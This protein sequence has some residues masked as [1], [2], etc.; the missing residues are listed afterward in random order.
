MIL[1][2]FT[3]VLASPLW[4][5][6]NNRNDCGNNSLS[7]NWTADL[8]AERPIFNDEDGEF[9]TLVICTSSSSFRSISSGYECILLS[10][11]LE[12]KRILSIYHA[13]D[14]WCLDYL[15]SPW[16]PTSTSCIAF[17]SVASMSFCCWSLFCP[18]LW[19][20]SV[21]DRCIFSL[22]FGW[23]LENCTL[24][25]KLVVWTTLHSNLSY[26]PQVIQGWLPD[27][28]RQLLHTRCF[29]LD[30]RADRL[31]FWLH[32][33]CSVG[34]VENRSAEWILALSMYRR[35]FGKPQRH[36][37]SSQL[38][39]SRTPLENNNV[40]KR[41]RRNQYLRACSEALP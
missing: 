34:F 24:L 33:E 40:G 28:V 36:A 8:A 18:S 13:T 17:L 31:L 4:S 22:T 3:V 12:G 19:L 14:M 41:Q 15:P 38:L 2:S 5:V 11:I 27:I 20:S 16:S 10:T 25:W 7:K 6:L 21:D 32:R 26:A 30:R 1:I 35:C 23:N 39:V 9:F 29:Y 37:Q